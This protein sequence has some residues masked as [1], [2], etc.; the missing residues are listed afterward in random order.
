MLAV[1]SP[2]S[3]LGSLQC[4][5]LCLGPEGAGLASEV[6]GLGQASGHISVLS[7]F[8]PG[9]FIH[10]CLIVSFIFFLPKH[11]FSDYT[12]LGTFMNLSWCGKGRNVCIKYFLCGG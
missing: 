12:F 7:K 6:S 10:P 3:P 2:P 5:V 8:P 1:R 9:S 11:V 4:C